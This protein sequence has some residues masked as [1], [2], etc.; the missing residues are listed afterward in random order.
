MFKS[1]TRTK[2]KTERGIIQSLHDDP[3]WI[4]TRKDKIVPAL[5]ACAGEIDRRGRNAFMSDQ[6]NSHRPQIVLQ[7]AGEGRLAGI[8]IGLQFIYFGSDQLGFAV[9]LV[10]ERDRFRDYTQLMHET[11]SMRGE[12]CASRIAG[13]CHAGVGVSYATERDMLK[14]VTWATEEL[15]PK[16]L[17]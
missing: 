5:K 10:R 7:W 4:A 12:D 16:W 11:V 8:R 14:R 6:V 17:C 15:R 13:L 1:H 9:G 3:N 2:F